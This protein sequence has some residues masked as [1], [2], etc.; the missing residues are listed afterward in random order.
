MSLLCIEL[1]V[2]TSNRLV[3]ITSCTLLVLAAHWLSIS[4]SI[5]PSYAF[6][7]LLFSKSLSLQKTTLTTSKLATSMLKI[8]SHRNKKKKK[9]RL[10]VLTKA[11]RISTSTDAFHWLTYV[12]HM[13]LNSDVTSQ[14]RL[15]KKKWTGHIQIFELNWMRW[16]SGMGVFKMRPDSSKYVPFSFLSLPFYNLL[17]L[18]RLQGLSFRQ[19]IFS[20]TQIIFRP[21]SSEKLPCGSSMQIA[22]NDRY[23]CLLLGGDL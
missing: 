6:C 12:L 21:S 17:L 10:A 13:H 3:W 8:K 9:T 7:V 19:K 23:L 14:I 22:N 20:C 18:V 16:F 2:N 1:N 5:L 11:V 15:K 4:V